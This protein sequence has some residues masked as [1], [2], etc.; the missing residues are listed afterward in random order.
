MTAYHDE[1]EN[2]SV[3]HH[4]YRVAHISEPAPRA[5]M[6]D[7]KKL[8]EAAEA[9]AAWHRD[10]AT[11]YELQAMKELG[12]AAKLE[13]DN[14]S[15]RHARCADAIIA[16]LDELDRQ[17]PVVVKP[18][19]WQRIGDEPEDGSVRSGRTVGWA[20]ESVDGRY[21]IQKRDG[22]DS[23]WWEVTCNARVVANA[24]DDDEAKAAAQKD[25]EARNRR[26][27]LAPSPAIGRET[28]TADWLDKFD[29]DKPIYT[30][31]ELIDLLGAL[32]QA[33]I[34]EGRINS[35]EELHGMLRHIGRSQR[36]PSPSPVIGRETVTE[37]MVERALA[38]QSLRLDRQANGEAATA[39]SEQAARIEELERALADC[40]KIAEDHGRDA[41]DT[42]ARGFR[43]GE[44][45]AARNMA[46]NIAADIAARRNRTTE[47]K[48]VP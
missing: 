23:P 39:L 18:L 38:V 40:V 8:R 42:A 7:R 46:R 43:T 1:D 6:T 17:E 35:I 15:A 36:A 34:R 30:D 5:Q 12:V 33:Q 19:E 16:L 27:A 44:E 11:S 24:E 37:E 31:R 22:S 10:E 29:G 45:R 21:L 13:L 20:A 14:T 48:D 2:L 4:A 25:Y 28:V 41:G 3:D 32:L 26:S 9:I 47:K